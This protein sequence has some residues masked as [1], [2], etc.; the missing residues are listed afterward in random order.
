MNRERSDKTDRHV[1]W[2][3]SV[4]GGGC[5][6]GRVAA[7]ISRIA[8]RSDDRVEIRVEYQSPS[9][10]GSGTDHPRLVAKCRG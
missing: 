10:M 2:N 5:V 3:G 7:G 6:S 8:R 1:G 4:V 9:R